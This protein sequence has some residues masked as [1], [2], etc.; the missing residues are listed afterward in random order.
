MKKIEPVKQKTGEVKE[1]EQ[2]TGVK[3]PLIYSENLLTFH[4]LIISGEADGREFTLEHS[5]Q[6]TVYVTIEGL[7]GQIAKFKIDPKDLITAAFEAAK[8][9]D[10]LEEL[11]VSK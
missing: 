5:L 8:K 6:G 9:H 10:L 11:E 3:V 1:S 2:A 7:K 4:Q